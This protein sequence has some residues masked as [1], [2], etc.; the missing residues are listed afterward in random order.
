[1]SRY[2]S[3]RHGLVY[4]NNIYSLRIGG[5][6]RTFKYTLMLES[7][8]NSGEHPAPALTYC[9]LTPAQQLLFA[10]KNVPFPTSTGL[11][12]WNEVYILRSYFQKWLDEN[13]KSWAMTPQTPDTFEP[14]SFYFDRRKD[15]L[16]FVELIKQI[17]SGLHIPKI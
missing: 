8:D 4:G 12:S 1:M 14:P 7:Y 17:L 9:L 10:E 16:A 11:T 6:P 3:K 13:T 5:E 15:V 2:I